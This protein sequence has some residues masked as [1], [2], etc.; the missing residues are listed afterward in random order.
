MYCCGVIKKMIELKEKGKGQGV[1]F[2]HLV[3]YYLLFMTSEG[4]KIYIFFKGTEDKSKT[5]RLVSYRAV[6]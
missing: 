3:V 2:I 1:V 4:K 5:H 6:L